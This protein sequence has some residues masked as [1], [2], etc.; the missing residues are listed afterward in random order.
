MHPSF[1]VEDGRSYQANAL[2]CTV[3]KEGMIR[4]QL[5]GGLAHMHADGDGIFF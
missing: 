4:W 3:S 1:L 2:V 5:F